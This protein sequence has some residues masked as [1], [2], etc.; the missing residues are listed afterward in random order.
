L[1]VHGQRKEGE[2]YEEATLRMPLETLV[3][4]PDIEAAIARKFASVKQR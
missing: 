2:S 4:A 1:I 3:S